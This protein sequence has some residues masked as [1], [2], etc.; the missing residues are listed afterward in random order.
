LHN[1]IRGGQ[2]LTPPEF[3]GSSQ[4]GYSL[5]L[6]VTL[7]TNIN[8][9]DFAARQ[10]MKEAAQQAEISSEHLIIALEPEAAVVFCIKNEEV[11]IFEKKLTLFLF[12]MI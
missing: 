9:Q 2:K 6:T 8:M 7:T 12:T 4:F 1:S 10:V 3:V 5:S 11:S